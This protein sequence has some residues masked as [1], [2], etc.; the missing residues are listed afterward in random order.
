M[1]EQRVADAKSLVNPSQGPLHHTTLGR[2]PLV[3]CICILQT[4]IEQRPS[5]DT[6]RCAS[7]AYST[8]HQHQ[9]VMLERVCQRVNK[10]RCRGTEKVAVAR[11]RESDGSLSISSGRYFTSLPGGSPFVYLHQPEAEGWTTFALFSPCYSSH[12]RRHNPSLPLTVLSMHAAAKLTGCGTKCIQVREWISKITHS[13]SHPC[14]AVLP[15][16]A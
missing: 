11:C 3:R 7:T 14:P 1:S 16:E 12:H 8:T 10:Q 4:S 2:R 9:R 5:P 13:V 15:D 6:W